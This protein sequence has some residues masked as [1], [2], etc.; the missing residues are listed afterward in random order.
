MGPHDTWFSLLPGWHELEA[1]YAEGL[2][3]DWQ[4]SAF[5]ATEFTLTHVAGVLLTIFVLLLATFAYRASLND[6]SKGVIPSAKFGLGAMADGFVRVVFSFTKDVL[7]EEDARRF[8]PLIGTFALFIF[9]CN[10]Q[11]L[12]PGLTPPT[13]TLKTNLAL[14]AMVFVIYNALGIYRNGL[15]YLAHFLG[16]KIG[17]FPWLMPLMLPI[18]LVSHV[19][20]PVTL[21]IRL[22]G[23]MVADHRVVAT[24]AGIVP[25]LL[26]V[27]FLV[28][29][30]MVCI[31]QTLIFTMLTITYIGMAIE[32]ADEH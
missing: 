13:D 11:G 15:S 5:G 16:P 26:P 6:E 4:A 27:P 8:L 22:T 9:V 32:H 12:V 19:A 29:G 28:L 1:R 21:A 25:L 2:R 31:V 20:R 17:G 30:T 3:R 23:N 10:I 7:G 18:E 14:S 24:F